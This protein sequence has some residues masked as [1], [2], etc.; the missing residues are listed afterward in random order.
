MWYVENEALKIF[1]YYMRGRKKNF[2]CNI[3]IIF[4]YMTSNNL[5]KQALGWIVVFHLYMTSNNLVKQA[6][7][8]IVV[9]HSYMT[10]NNLVKQ[11]LGWMLYH[12]LLSDY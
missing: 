7:G 4:H 5:V 2:F 1:L 3:L 12:H 11:A 6:L 10:S 9:F 8:W